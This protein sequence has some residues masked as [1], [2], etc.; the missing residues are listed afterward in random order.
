MR[1][2]DPPAVNERVA[3]E[4]YVYMRR[5]F[6]GFHHDGLVR[7]WHAELAWTVGT[8]VHGPEITL[9]LSWG[10]DAFCSETHSGL[11]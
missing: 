8:D 9:Q 3:K 2:P 11:S 1:S 5:A 10:A 7:F 6:V 4:G